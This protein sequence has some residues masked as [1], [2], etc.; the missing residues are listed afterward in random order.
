MFVRVRVCAC[1]G[2]CMHV[3]VGVCM[4][5]RVG[6]HVCVNVHTRMCVQTFIGANDTAWVLA[7]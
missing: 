3:R 1:V 2:V 7:F 5:V 6:V 4:H